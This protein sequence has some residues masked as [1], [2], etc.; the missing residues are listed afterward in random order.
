MSEEYSNP[1]LNISL[2]LI[3][4]LV[5]ESGI[6]LALNPVVVATLTNFGNALYPSPPK[7]KFISLIDPLSVFELVEYFKVLVLSELYN[8]FSGLLEMNLMVV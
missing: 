1:I 2:F 5:V 8:K 7:V 6:I 3:L 4:L